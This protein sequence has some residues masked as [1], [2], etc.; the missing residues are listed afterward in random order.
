M[1]RQGWIYKRRFGSCLEPLEAS[2]SFWSSWCWPW[3]WPWPGWKVSL[4]RTQGTSTF[5]QTILQTEELSMSRHP[6]LPMKVVEIGESS[7]MPRDCHRC[8]NDILQA[9]ITTA[10]AAPTSTLPSMEPMRWRNGGVNQDPISQGW[11][12]KF[13]QVQG[14]EIIVQIPTMKTGKFFF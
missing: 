2:S 4:P 5:R 11:G 3:P 6:G 13:I 7:R 14:E 10:T 12:M 9:S 8:F 1:K